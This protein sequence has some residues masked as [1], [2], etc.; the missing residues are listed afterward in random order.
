MHHLQ[1]YNT[2]LF[3]DHVMRLL[4]GEEDMSA[5][6][7][8]SKMDMSS[9][10]ASANI[11]F[12]GFLSMVEYQEAVANN[13]RDHTRHAAIVAVYQGYTLVHHFLVCWHVNSAPSSALGQ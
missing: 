6:T 3:Y 11:T 5:G 4:S 12:H 9:C 2:S 1:H 13:M 8:M 7:L 10:L